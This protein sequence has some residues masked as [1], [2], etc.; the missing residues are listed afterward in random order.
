MNI[1]YL[2]LSVLVLGLIAC[3]E[4]HD[5]ESESVEEII[6]TD[7]IDVKTVEVVEDNVEAKIDFSKFDHYATILT[8]NDLI[9]KF[10]E[11]NLE[12]RTVWY[13]EGTVERQSTILTNPDNG[14]VVKYVWAEEDNST[15]SWIEATHYLWNEAFSIEGT[16]TLETE[17]GL[18]L[19]MSLAELRE[20]NEADFKFS[21]F[22]WDYAGG[23]FAEKGSNLAD[24]KVQVNLM[25]D[26]VASN[27]GFDFMIGD[28]EL[29]ADDEKLIDAPVLVEQFS[30]YIDNEK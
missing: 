28:V 6:I 2:Y 8:K 23:V 29:H 16:Q 25:N 19:G 22:G 17:N 9:A 21:G 14:H 26:Q 27:E 5:P 20:W 13:A 1:K 15:T 10:G 4:S 11:E 3:G 30:L 12:D 7:P 24:S 18:K